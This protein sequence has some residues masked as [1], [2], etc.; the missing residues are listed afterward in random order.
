MFNFSYELFIKTTFCLVIS[1]SFFSAH[2]LFAKFFSNGYNSKYKCNLNNCLKNDFSWWYSIC[3]L[4]LKILT[5]QLLS[6]ILFTCADKMKFTQALYQH[7]Q[8]R[9]YSV[10][11]SN[12]N[13]IRLKLSSKVVFCVTL[14]NSVIKPHNDI[15]LRHNLNS[16]P[17]HLDSKRQPINSNKIHKS[18]IC[19][20]K[21]K[22]N[23]LGNSLLN[24]IWENIFIFLEIFSF[25]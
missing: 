4:R 6:F 21:W 5:Q 7:Q 13:K 14:E 12:R 17:I 11:P 15:C 18:F 8:K 19:I 9:K 24:E 25:F 3:L 20:R 16:F 23:I 10:S 2:Q 22:A 1:Y